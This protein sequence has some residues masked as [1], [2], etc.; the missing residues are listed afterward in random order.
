MLGARAAQVVA[1]KSA[2]IVTMLRAELFYSLFE[3]KAKLKEY[4]SL[5][6]YINKPYVI[7][8]K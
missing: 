8:E 2:L 3:N 7:S 6:K 5:E 4:Y 1:E